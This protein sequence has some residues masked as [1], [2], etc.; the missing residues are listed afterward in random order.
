MSKLEKEINGKVISYDDLKKA[1]IDSGINEN[2]F[3]VMQSSNLPKAGEFTGY[4]IVETTNADDEKIAF[5]QLI[6][7]DAKGKEY[8]CSLGRLAAMGKI[9]NGTEDLKETDIATS[10]N[11]NLYIRGSQINPEI[12]S[13]PAIAILETVGKKFKKCERINIFNAE[14]KAGGYQEE[15]KEE[16]MKKMGLREVFQLELID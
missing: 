3:N 11:G 4:E 2:R 16:F 13:N 10:R 9:A 5:V 15:E 7:K 14:Y 1:L 12:S 6:A 8:K